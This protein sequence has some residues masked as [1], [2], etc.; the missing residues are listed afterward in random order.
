M[1]DHWI[2]NSLSI[3]KDAKV[4][5]YG[6]P[7]DHSAIIL[8]LKFPKEKKEE[9]KT[10]TN[11]DW[12]MFLEEDTKLAFNKFLKENLKKYNF[13]SNKNGILYTTFSDILMKS[14][15]VVLTSKKIDSP[16]WF[17]VSRNILQPL[18]DER[19]KILNKIRQIDLDPKLA[20]HLASSARRN[21]NDGIVLA[22][23][24]WT[25]FLAEKFIFCQIFLKKLGDL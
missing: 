12:N 15:K 6:V 19:T 24:R 23:S 16:G 3:I 10:T 20:K 21:V 2:T 22:K 4:I 11:I 18:I 5:D 13:T 1:L 25:N 14:A 9:R 7:G 8:I 17:N